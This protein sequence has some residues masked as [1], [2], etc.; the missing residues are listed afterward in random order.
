VVPRTQTVR[1]GRTA[2]VAV[3]EDMRDMERTDTA[4]KDAA[5]E[6]HG[7]ADQPGKSGRGLG[8]RGMGHD[9]HK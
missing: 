9:G 8:Q 6:C 1:A 3:V 5:S 4:A 7:A 2:E